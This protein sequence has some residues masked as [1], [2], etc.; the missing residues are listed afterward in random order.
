MMIDKWIQR[1]DLHKGSFS[2]AVGIP[3]ADDIPMILIDDIIKSPVG[4]KLRNPS[5]AGKAF[6]VV[7]AKLKKQAVLAR[8]LKKIKR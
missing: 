7:T 5:M 1:A 8:N 3:E 6:I 2:R 4:F